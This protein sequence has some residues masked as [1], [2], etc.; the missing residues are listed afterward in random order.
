MSAEPLPPAREPLA[1]TAEDEELAHVLDHYLAELEAG[2]PT[3]PATLFAQHPTIADRLRS[4]LSSLQVVEQA[5]SDLP[6]ATAQPL[7]PPQ[8]SDFRILREIGRGGMGIVYEAEQLSLNR[9]VALKVLPFAA[10]LDPR[11]LQRFRHEAQAAA[12]L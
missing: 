10:A 2:R 1:S 12:H 7:P 3:D 8:L 5:L 6:S 9:R 11:H 4:C